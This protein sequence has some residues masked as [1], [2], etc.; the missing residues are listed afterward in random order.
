M[1]FNY[2]AAGANPEVDC[3]YE[4][5]GTGGAIG[6]SDVVVVD[7]KNEKDIHDGPAGEYKPVPP[8]STEV[9]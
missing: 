2:D 4:T 5:K 1:I 9:Y 6:L 8:R 7:A 3:G